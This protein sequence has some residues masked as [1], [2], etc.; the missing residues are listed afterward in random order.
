MK[1]E[2]KKALE[3][4][5]KRLEFARSSGGVDPDETK[6]EQQARI[7]KAKKDVAFM[8]ETYFPQYATAPCAEFQIQYANIVA[9]NPRVRIFCEWGRGMAKSVWNTI[10]IPFWLWL[11]GEDVY[12]VIVGSSFNKASQLLDDLKAEF[13]GNPRIIHDFGEQINSGSWEDGF[14]I[15]KSGFIGQALGMGQSVR[16]LRVKNLRPN[17]IVPDDTETK[18]LTKNEQRQNETV[19]YIERDLIPTMDG[20]IARF[21]FSNTRHAPRLVQTLL[22]EKHPEWRVHHIMAYDPVTKLPRWKEKYADDYYLKLEEEIGVLAA[23][24]EYCHIAHVEG[25]IFKDEQIQWCPLPALNHFKIIFGHWDIAYA[26]NPKSDYNAVRIWGLKDKDFY[27]ITSFVKQCK[28]RDAV[29]FICQYQLNLPKTVTVHWRFEA[30]FWNDAVQQTINEVCESF[31]FYGTLISSVELD[32][33]K[34]YDRILRLQPYY[35]NG[36][37]WYNEKMKSHNDTQVGLA[38]LK[39]IEPNYKTHDDAPD[40]DEAA[41]SQLE[42]YISSKSKSKPR[43]GKIKHKYQW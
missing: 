8:V 17:F 20:A 6:E 37:I 32:K 9:R 30:Q 42:K 18:E 4:Y 21:C 35:Q 34:K 28:M 41:I 36:R 5:R 23:Q 26:G 12:L 33:R 31:G 29:A 43:I 10:F 2:D 27:Y 39:A 1:K 11:R 13:E 14:F 16:G 7:K 38:Q 19:D 22:Q 40:A 3:A 15:T 24:A 25:K